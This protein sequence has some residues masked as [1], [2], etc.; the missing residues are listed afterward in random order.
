MKVLSISNEVLVGYMMD[1]ENKK[2]C[3]GGWPRPDTSS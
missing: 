1:K 2:G 3:T